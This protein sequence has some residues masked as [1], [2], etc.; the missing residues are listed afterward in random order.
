MN[1]HVRRALVACILVA[2]TGCAAVTRE[3]ALT[4]AKREL[5]RRHCMLPPNYTVVVG[6]GVFQAEFGS[7]RPLWEVQF[8]APTRRGT[9]ALYVV[10]ISRQ[11]GAVDT[12]SDIR[13]TV[14]SRM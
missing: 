4:T 14:P 12:F 11:S 9:K 13:Q 1:S 7:P 3:Q 8:S 6:E 2:C 10:L 5:A